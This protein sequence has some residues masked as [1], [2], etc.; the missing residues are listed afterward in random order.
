MGSEGDDLHGLD[1]EAADPLLNPE[2]VGPDQPEGPEDVEPQ[3]E[4]DLEVAEIE[5]LALDQRWYAV[6]EVE[7]LVHVP[8]ISQLELLIIVVK[9]VL[10]VCVGEAVVDPEVN[11]DDARHRLYPVDRPTF[12]LGRDRVQVLIGLVGHHLLL[13]VVVLMPL[14]PMLVLYTPCVMSCLIVVALCTKPKMPDHVPHSFVVFFEVLT[15]I[16]VSEVVSHVVGCTAKDK[17][18]YVC[19]ANDS[20]EPSSSHRATFL[21][22][23]HKG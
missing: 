17:I 14:M 21:K 10:T 15:M 7:L 23:E 6:P 13:R 2:A 1:L 8:R 11:E 4:V 5:G 9:P 16:D 20:E 18:N 12:I 19:K 3:L 22:E